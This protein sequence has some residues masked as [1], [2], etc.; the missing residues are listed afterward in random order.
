[1]KNI[2]GDVRSWSVGKILEY[3]IASKVVVV[4]GGIIPALIAWAEKLPYTVL[5]FGGFGGIAL[6][7]CLQMQFNKQ[8]T[9]EFPETWLEF[10]IQNSCIT[11]QDGS[12]SPS[13][14]FSEG[15]MMNVE[16]WDIIPY[17][18]YFVVYLEFQS[19]FISY[20]INS[21]VH[22]LNGKEMITIDKTFLGGKYSTLIFMNNNLDMNGGKYRLIVNPKKIQNP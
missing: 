3:I 17:D 15:E 4:L 9:K 18:R 7:K 2:F 19:P 20:K 5:W 22:S 11:A 12:K 1:M 10:T 16:V 8:S 14:I 6:V 21:E 13:L